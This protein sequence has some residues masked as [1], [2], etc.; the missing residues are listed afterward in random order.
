MNEGTGHSLA[1]PRENRNT[2]EDGIRRRMLGKSESE[3]LERQE[4]V[5][6]EEC[7]ESAAGLDERLG[8]EEGAGEAKTHGA[9][10][11]GAYQNINPERWRLSISRGRTGAIVV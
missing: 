7:I 4:K 9:I 1:K 8:H 3:K 6:G 2:N 10:I 11:M 5:H